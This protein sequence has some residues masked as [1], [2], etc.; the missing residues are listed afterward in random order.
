MKWLHEMVGSHQKGIVTQRTSEEK[1]ALLFLEDTFTDQS[2]EML[3]YY[4]MQLLDY[5]QKREYQVLVVLDVTSSNIPCVNILRW[6]VLPQLSVF[7]LGN[8]ISL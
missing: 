6:R 1:A 5:C 7:N 3:D 8:L 2:Q 4:K